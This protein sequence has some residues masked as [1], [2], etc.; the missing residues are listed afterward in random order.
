MHRRQKESS[1]KRPSLIRRGILCLGALREI[2]VLSFSIALFFAIL[3][4]S[5]TMAK[6]WS[7]P[8]ELKSRTDDSKP[9]LNMVIDQDT[10]TLVVHSFPGSFDEFEVKSGSLTRHTGVPFLVASAFAEQTSTRILLLEWADEVSV[11]HDVLILRDNEVLI[12]E[13]IGLAVGMSADVRVAADGSTAVVVAHDGLI[14][15]WDLSAHD[16]S[17]WQYRLDQRVHSSVISPDG[18]HLFIS[19]FDGPGKILQTRTGHGEVTL[20]NVVCCSRC[21]AWSSD[22]HYLATGLLSGEA[23][24]Y[25][26]STGK[27]IW[28][29]KLDFLFPRSIALSTHGEWLAVGGFDKT[30]RVWNLCDPSM[31]VVELSGEPGVVH[32]LL[33]ANS[34]RTLFSG[35]SDGSIREWSV[36]DRKQIRQL[37]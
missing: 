1:T 37:R 9:V 2:V 16:F 8:A 18:R 13:K 36:T 30:I 7:Q 32:N 11:H 3:S 35:S 34:D 19:D 14:T 4:D 17:R 12:S 25:E 27:Q 26:A 31:S 24:V 21:T 22:G 28:E 6:F 5:G 33:F 29:R 10:Q 23:R 15:G 20:S